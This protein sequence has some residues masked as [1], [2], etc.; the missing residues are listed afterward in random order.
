MT[1]TPAAEWFATDVDLRHNQLINARAENASTA[2]ANPAKGQLWFDDSTTPGQLKYFDGAKWTGG[3]TYYNTVA[4]DGTARPQRSRLDVRSTASMTATVADDAPNDTSTLTMD[5]RFGPVAVSQVSGAAS[6]DGVAATVARSDHQHGTPPAA[7]SD[8]VLTAWWQYDN[9]LWEQQ[10]PPATF[11]SDLPGQTVGGGWLVGTGGL[12]FWN[13]DP[14]PIAEASIYRDAARVSAVGG[15]AT[16]SMGWLCYDAEHLLLGAVRS[17]NQVP[18]VPAQESGILVARNEVPN[19]SAEFVGTPT[20]P[21][22]HSN[23]AFG[24]GA[25]AAVDAYNT[26]NYFSR[27]HAVKASWPDLGTQRLSNVMINPP[28]VVPVGTVVTLSAQVYVPSGSPDVRLDVLYNV[29]GPVITAKDRWVHSEVSFTTPVTTPRSYFV[30]LSTTAPLSGTYAWLDEVAF[31]VGSAPLPDGRT[32][33]DGATPST[34]TATFVWDG[35]DDDSPSSYYTIEP[36]WT[37]VEGYLAAGSGTEPGAGTSADIDS[38]VSPLPGA[39]YFRPFVSCSAGQLVVDTHEVARS[40]R[41]LRVIDG[42]RAGWVVS[43]G[44][45]QAP[46][47]VTS[48]VSPPDTEP[49]TLLRI[50][51]VTDPPEQPGDVTPRDYVDRGLGLLP[52]ETVV[53]PRFLWAGTGTDPQPADLDFPFAAWPLFA[54]WLDTSV[55]EARITML[56]GTWQGATSGL[57]PALAAGT[58]KP[59]PLTY[60]VVTTVPA[61]GVLVGISQGSAYAQYSDY[62][63]LRSAVWSGVDD[64][65]MGGSYVGSAAEVIVSGSSVDTMFPRTP[66]TVLSVVPVTAGTR[67]MGRTEYGHGGDSAVVTRDR[68]LMVYLPGAAKVGVA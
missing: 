56:T 28:V 63:L 35:A 57:C 15:S 47:V 31:R 61:D 36:S 34:D 40:P 42:M 67:Y 50:G 48:E 9:Q 26:E 3:R 18:V 25:I 45:A 16:L 68:T 1:T 65:G 49:P 21:V 38:A 11:L 46:E 8:T 23:G 7:G 54:Q 24:D 27:G 41:D 5:A 53:S 55:T 14:V 4:D 17:S 58:W 64:D 29:T 30:G 37:G 20:S 43:D 51:P 33:F 22:W 19:P 2:P 6:S 62:L 44:P 13:G 39:M 60:R 32:Y 12:I 10:S 59:V 52:E 66:Y